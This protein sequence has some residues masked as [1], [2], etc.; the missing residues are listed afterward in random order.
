MNIASVS[1]TLANGVIPAQWPSVAAMQKENLSPEELKCLS[2]GLDTFIGRL[3][4]QLEALR[5]RLMDAEFV[6]AL[7][8][9]NLRASTDDDVA[10]LDAFVEKY[11]SVPLSIETW[12]RR[13][14]SFHFGQ[15]GSQ[16]FD[17]SC[18]FH[19]MHR[20]YQFTMP[21]IATACTSRWDAM[22]GWESDD[23][24]AIMDNGKVFFMVEDCGMD[25]DWKGFG[26]PD[27]SVDPIIDP[28]TGM[29]FLR[30]AEHQ[31]K[32]GGFGPLER[33]LSER[34]SEDI[35]VEFLTAVFAP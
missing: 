20:F 11:R 27:G 5:D 7:P 16:M 15:H 18:G 1:T 33:N 12:Y 14:A 24:E 8:D 34:T 4:C 31:T 9:H 28:E 3:F 13:I 30:W 6:F 22:I 10:A 26:L 21:P 32:W 29:T 25:E 19:F 35:N 2:F 23:K 17:H